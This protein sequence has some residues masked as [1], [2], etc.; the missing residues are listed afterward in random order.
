METNGMNKRFWGRGRA[1]YDRAG[2]ASR[3]GR[4]AP[5]GRVRSSGPLNSF[6]HHIWVILS[7]TSLQEPPSSHPNPGHRDSGWLVL[8]LWGRGG[9]HSWKAFVG[10]VSPATSPSSCTES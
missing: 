1:G 6:A 4:A 8:G 10:E 3:S 7:K 5:R 9:L 2:E